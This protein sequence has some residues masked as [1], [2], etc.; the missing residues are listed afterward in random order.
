MKAAGFNITAVCSR[1][2][3]LSP[4]TFAERHG[5]PHVFDDPTSLLASGSIWD[6]LLIAV[7]PEATLPILRQA[8]PLGVPILVEKPAAS[9]AAELK[10]LVERR[11]PVLVGYNRRFYRPVKALRA[12]VSQSTG[13]FLGHLVLSEPVEAAGETDPALAFS[14]RVTS[15]SV[16]AFDLLRFVF[17]RLELSFARPVADAGGRLAGLTAQLRAVDSGSLVSVSATWNAPANLSLT[18]LHPGLRAVLEPFE[19]LRLYRSMERI[20]PSAEMPLRRYVPQQSAHVTLDRTDL[21]FK[22]GFYR[23]AE[24]LKSLVRGTAPKDVATLDDAYHAL[25]LAEEVLSSLQPER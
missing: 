8:V 24:A 12:I 2:G 25:C 21:A 6:A 23:Q 7:P 4:Y 3:S 9:N 5:I 11:Y 13:A 14:R 10:P 19:E 1:A 22:P 16:H 17:G 15:N 18:L 20:E